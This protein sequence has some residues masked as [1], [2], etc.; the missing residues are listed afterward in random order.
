MTA[1]F[2]RATETQPQDLLGRL[3]HAITALIL[4]AG[5]AFWSTPEILAEENGK[6]LR[7]PNIVFILA[8]D[9]YECPAYEAANLRDNRQNT[10]FSTQ[11]QIAGNCREFRG[12]AG[13]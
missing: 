10:A 7:R 2:P 13:D 9:K 11:S 8:D 1:R 12:I 4:V 5:A 3:L 6:E